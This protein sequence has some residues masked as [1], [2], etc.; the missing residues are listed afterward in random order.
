[1]QVSK[2]FVIQEFVPPEIYNLF[3]DKR[4]CL[5]YIRPEIIQAAQLLRDIIGEPLTLNNWHTGGAFTARGYRTPKMKVGAAYSQHRLGCAIDV[6]CAAHK[7]AELINAMSDN[8]EKFKALGIRTIEN[9][10]YT[11]SWVHMDCRAALEFYPTDNFY[12]VNP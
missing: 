3:D 9:P 10:V 6:S 11:T 5:W 1:M 2:N 4:K 12:F 7:P 8:F